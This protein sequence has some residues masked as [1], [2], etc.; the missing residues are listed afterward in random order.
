MPKKQKMAQPLPPL[1]EQIPLPPTPELQQNLPTAQVPFPP[2]VPD[3]Q[4][5]MSGDGGIVKAFESCVIEVNN[6]EDD[7]ILHE[8]KPTDFIVSQAVQAQH[9]ASRRQKGEEPSSS[10]NT[11]QQNA[12]HVTMDPK[13]MIVPLPMMMGSINGKPVKVL[14][15]TGSTVT[16]VP[17]SLIDEMKAT[18]IPC[19]E[20]FFG[21]GTNNIPIY[22]K[23]E[24]H[25]TISNVSI[26]ISAAVTDGDQFIFAIVDIIFGCDSMEKLGTLIFKFSK[27]LVEIAPENDEDIPSTSGGTD[28]QTEYAK[29]LIEYIFDKKGPTDPKIPCKDPKDYGEL[30]QFLRAAHEYARNDPQM[31]EAIRPL[32]ELLASG[33][34]KWER[35]HKAAYRRTLGLLYE[36]FSTVNEEEAQSRLRAMGF[37]SQD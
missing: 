8:E 19:N 10:T 15:D 17:K 35:K 30:Q 37:P 26:T 34:F 12:V 21:L 23:A 14:M 24:L 2:L 27:R 13:N 16:I 11:H 3:D 20:N 29:W 1:I 7:A 5:K 28:E 32:M 6:E 18:V 25:I 36:F 33:K 22:G 4:P 31:I 9:R